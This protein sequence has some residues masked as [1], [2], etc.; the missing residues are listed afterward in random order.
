MEY[1]ELFLFKNLSENQINEISNIQFN[2]K[3]FKKG[4]IIYCQNNFSN[5]IGFVIKGT[6]FAVS[7]N[8]NKIHLKMFEKNMCFGAA[9]VFGGSTNYVSTITAKTDLEV[10]F[11]T[12]D[13]LKNLFLNYPQTAINYI[14]FLS[15]KVRFLNNKLSIISCT[16]AEDTVLNYLSTIADACGYAQIPHNMTLLSKTLGI[17]RASLYRTLDALQEN[18]H[19]IRENNKIKVIKNE[20]NY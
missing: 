16:N 5:A 6:A 8:Q 19:I 12:E 13:E 10:L 4:E 18:G 15:D 17:S 3:S 9:A 14:T 20:K 11:I 2:I 1:S 7:N